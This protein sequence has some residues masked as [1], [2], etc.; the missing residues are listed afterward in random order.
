MLNPDLILFQ[1][2][3]STL[4]RQSSLSKL[5]TSQVKH[6]ERNQ[7]I[8]RRNDQRAVAPRISA[9]IE[10]A[11][12]ERDERKGKRDESNHSEESGDRQ[13]GYR[14]LPYADF[15]L[16][17]LRKHLQTRRDEIASITLE[18]GDDLPD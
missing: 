11:G 10:N 5:P 3:E 16:H 2:A 6:S 13:H 12:E 18:L 14:Y 1:N 8:S 17:L 9:A 15:L 4:R 7:E